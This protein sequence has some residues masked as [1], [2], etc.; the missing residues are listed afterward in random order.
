MSA[1]QHLAVA[2]HLRRQAHDLPA[3]DPRRA[4][5]RARARSF[6]ALARRA[7]DED[8]PSSIITPLVM[9]TEDEIASLRTDRHM[10]QRVFA[11]RLTPTEIARLRQ[12]AKERSAYYRAYFANLKPKQ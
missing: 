2:L 11:P 7:R 1:D 5:T 9:L 6:L 4:E 3:S 10:S 12:R 8:W